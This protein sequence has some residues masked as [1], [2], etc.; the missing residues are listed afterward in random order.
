[1]KPVRVLVN[2]PEGWLV[3]PPGEYLIG[4][5]DDCAIVLANGRVSRRHARLVVSDAG[6]VLEDLASANG[7]YVNGVRVQG[8]TTLSHDDFIVIGE[9]GIE[10]AYQSPAEPQST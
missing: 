5:A 3:F 10:I 7:T 9:I 1:M 6:A 4:R 8:R 2:A